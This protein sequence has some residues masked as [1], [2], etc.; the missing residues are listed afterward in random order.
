LIRAAG[1]I[2][3]PLAFR[4]EVE[5]REH[6]P[7]RG[8]L[9]VVGNHVAVM[10]AVLMAVMTPW[11]V[12]MLASMD[13]P[14]ERISDWSIRFYGGIHIQRGHFERAA[15]RQALDVLRQGGIL[16]VFPEGGIWAAGGMRPQTGVAWLSYRTQ[17]PVLPIGFSGTMGALGAAL[18][19][20]RPRLRMEVGPVLP[21][22]TMKD[23]MARK[24]SLEA[25]AR[26]VL[27]AIKGLVPAG[28]RMHQAQVEDEHFALEVSVVDE[29]GAPV[30]V[31]AELAITHGEEV[32]LLL[33][34]PGLLK[35]FRQNLALP[36]EALEMVDR[37]HDP[38][39]LAVGAASI[40]DYL[41]EG[42]PY[43]L[44]YRLGPKAAEAT[45]TGLR[46]LVALARWAEAQGDTLHLK[47]IRRY[48]SPA[49]GREIVQV[50]QG[51]FTDWM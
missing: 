13:V 44:T 39:A 19:L 14:H 45:E 47:P 38:Q 9:L 18:K 41:H 10:E 32:A 30:A 20:E 48:Y 27:E 34:R 23:G 21:P 5:G 7:E 25:Y 37:A 6:F 43:L 3:L 26:R 50:E 11:Q 8:P 35:I 33:H 2:V 51:E 12:E 46:E 36:V 17:S 1:R 16:G 4:L 40:L 28:D 49:E 15:L 31:P 29:E 42:N 24:A 22:A